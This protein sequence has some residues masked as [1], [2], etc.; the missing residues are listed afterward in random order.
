MEINALQLVEAV[1]SSRL[2]R[3]NLV[4]RQVQSLQIGQLLKRA[5]RDSGDRVQLQ[6]QS[7]QRWHI[8]V[9]GR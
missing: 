1:E 4:V 6:A 3:L 7:H 2:D 9:Q 5:S 8:G